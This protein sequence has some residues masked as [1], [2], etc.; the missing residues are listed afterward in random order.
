[1]GKVVKDLQ[2]NV[3]SLRPCG[4]MSSNPI[5]QSVFETIY[6]EN[7]Y[8]FPHNE[9]RKS[10]GTYVFV[11]ILYDMMQILDVYLFHF[12]L[13]FPTFLSLGTIVQL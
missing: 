6:I 10:I 5:H 12:I 13:V 11:S 4:Q 1:M 7:F 9:I 3:Y 2:Q 8:A